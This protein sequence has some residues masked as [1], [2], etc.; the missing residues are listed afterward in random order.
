MITKY[1]RHSDKID[2]QTDFLELL[3]RF[4]NIVEENIKKSTYDPDRIVAI[5]F[6]IAEIQQGYELLRNDGQ[7]LEEINQMISELIETGNKKYICISIIRGI[8]TKIPN[9]IYFDSTNPRNPNDTNKRSEIIQKFYGYFIEN[10]SSV[11]EL[12]QNVFDDAN[13]RLKL[14]NLQSKLLYTEPLYIKDYFDKIKSKIIKHPGYSTE[15]LFEYLAENIM[16]HTSISNNARDYCNH[17]IE[18]FETSLKKKSMQLLCNLVFKLNKDN[19]TQLLKKVIEKQHSLMTLIKAKVGNQENSMN[20]IKKLVENKDSSR[21]LIK[22]IDEN[23]DSVMDSMKKIVKNKDAVINLMKEIDDNK[24]VLKSIYD[25]GIELFLI[26]CPIITNSINGQP[27]KSSDVAAIQDLEQLNEKFKDLL[28]ELSSEKSI[29]NQLQNSIIDENNSM[30]THQILG[31]IYSLRIKCLDFS[32]D[33]V[34]VKYCF[35]HYF[36]KSL[37][38]QNLD[39][40]KNFTQFNRLLFYIHICNDDD[41]DDTLNYTEDTH[42]SQLFELK[43]VFG[44]VEDAGNGTNIDDIVEIFKILIHIRSL[45]FRLRCAIS[46]LT[47][48]NNDNKI[49][50]KGTV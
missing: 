17:F 22:K 11:R 50:V 2:Q 35:N 9:R 12:L 27:V 26:K 1:E 16:L 33:I 28:S 7:T 4:K 3:T 20:I 46:I 18:L 10:I 29:L 21:N 30:G 32:D 5:Y 48:L 40:L 25:N 6:Y 14:K 37:K 49:H 19:F 42:Q 23:K 47:D 31:E 45:I 36:F 41:D 39:D 24:S 8:E 43:T 34:N 44:K 38:Y 15:V 13:Y